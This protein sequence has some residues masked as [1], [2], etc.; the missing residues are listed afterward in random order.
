MNKTGSTSIQ[1]FLF[2]NQKI[3]N[4]HGFCYPL[5]GINNKGIHYGVSEAFGFHH[6][7]KNNI[8][9]ENKNIKKNSSKVL[10]RIRNAFGFYHKNIKEDSSKVLSDLLTEI[11]QSGARKVFISSE[12][13]VMNK[14]ISTIEKFFKDFDVKIVVFLRRHDSWEESKYQQGLKTV[15]NPPW[16]ANLDDYLKFQKN[17]KS[18]NYRHLLDKW[19]SVFGKENIIV[20]PFEKQQLKPS[21]IEVLLKKIGEENLYN[22][23]THSSS[24]LNSSLSNKSCRLLEIYQRIDID[25]KIRSKLKLYAFTI[26]D[27]GEKRYPM[28]DEDRSL[29]GG[30]GIAGHG[31]GF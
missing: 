26:K 16:E 1:D 9:H 29:P 11:H 25:E 15:A 21:L 6:G 23:H 30:T 2:N 14:D 19:S 7:N 5:T 22:I 18:N 3:F 13:F 4:L 17:K 27:E 24:R 20:I 12:H 28:V 10:G 8:K 31:F